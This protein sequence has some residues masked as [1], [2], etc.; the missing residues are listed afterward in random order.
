VT[1]QPWYGAIIQQEL[2]RRGW[3]QG[4]LARELELTEKH[5]SQ[6]LNGRAPMRLDTLER[7]LDPLGLRLA[8]MIRKPD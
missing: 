2:R 6:L 5:L 3:T 7:M 1:E 4:D 8:I